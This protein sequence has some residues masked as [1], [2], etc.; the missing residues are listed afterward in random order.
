MPFI[1]N[2]TGVS[3]PSS[4]AMVAATAGSAGAFTVTITASCGPRSAGLSLA[5]SFTLIVASG[6]STVRPLARIAARCAPRA[7]TD[8]SAPPRARL[9]AR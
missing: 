2:A 7:T 1:G 3:G 8:T 6:V 9:P 5:G 4:G